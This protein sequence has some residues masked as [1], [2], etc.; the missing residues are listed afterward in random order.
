MGMPFLLTVISFLFQIHPHSQ[1]ASDANDL[2]WIA[3]WLEMNN[4]IS[5]GS[6]GFNGSHGF[7]RAFPYS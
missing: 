4:K 3:K 2:N 5:N 1:R 6:N 7:L